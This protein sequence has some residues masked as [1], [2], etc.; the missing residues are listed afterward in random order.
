MIYRFAGCVLDTG[1]HRLTR[2]GQEQQVEPQVFDLLTLLLDH[3]GELVTKDR[4]VDE[5]WGG[6]AVSE[7]AISAR[8]AALRKAV[9][10]DGKRQSIVRTVSR[11]GLQLVAAVT[12]EQAAPAPF[13][14]DD[15]P[16]VRFATARDGTKIAYALSGDGPPL[17]RIPYFP[18]HLEL[19]WSEPS[20]RA[21]FDELGQSRRLVRFDQR[22]CG[23]S[24]RDVAQYSVMMTVSDALA[25][26]DELGLERFDLLAVSGGALAAAE[27]AA[28]A[29]ERVSSLILL[30]G[31]VQG[32]SI[33]A[34]KGPGAAADVMTAMI[35]EGWNQSGNGFVAGFL[36]AYF[37][38][39]DKDVI[40]R[41]VAQ[42]QASCSLDAEV[43][44][45]AAVDGH[46]LEPAL[47]RISAPTLVMHCS[48]DSVHPVEQGRSLARGIA[49]AEL[50]ILDSNN[51]FP[52]PG[53]KSW[54]QML[55]AMRQ[56]LG[57][58]EP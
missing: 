57:R 17:L 55:S 34:G 43:A 47:S 46:L 7:S 5:I 35:T 3:A 14:A 1:A 12:P 10:D 16:P 26:A 31:Y 50:K 20:E 11:R 8:I 4:I 30:G 6:R 44:Y 58:A 32:R 13:R 49:G 19:D 42:F 27:L 22:G 41:Y 33:R 21:L 18:T 45:R 53:D 29:P 28:A 48:G 25:V 51:H 52:M 37:P 24:D 54:P 38:S 56:F 40:A 15:Q 9:G 36:S 2:D 23:L 39:V